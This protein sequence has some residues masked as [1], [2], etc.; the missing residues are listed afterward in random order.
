MG[1][2]RQVIIVGD[3][4][5]LPP[6]SFFERRVEDGGEE[7]TE[8]ETHDLDSILDEC[9]GAGI[10][11]VELTWHYRS[12]HE[13]LIAFSNNTYYG[14]RLVTFPSPVTSDQAVSF[15]H[16]PGG[17]YARAA[18]RTNEVEARAVVAEALRVLRA[19]PPRSLGIVTF[20]AEQQSLIEDLFDRA[21][22]DDP[23]LEHHFGDDAAEPV[24]V[25]NLEGI[26]GE[27]RD[28]MLFSLTYGPDQTGSIG[29]NFGPLNLTGGERRLNVAVTR[30]REKL[31]VFGS[32]RADQIDLSRTAATGVAHLKQFLEFAE[33]GARAFATEATG[34]LGDHESPFEAEVA[35][36]L[37]QKGWVVHP[38]IGVSGFRIDLAVVDPD[39]PGAF[40]AGVECDGATYHRAAT[41][42]D[43]DR[44]RQMVLE[45][46]GWSILRI[47][48]TDWWTNAGR[49]TD[50][51]HAALEAALARAR[52]R[53]QTAALTVADETVRAD[54]TSQADQTILEPAELAASEAQSSEPASS[55]GVGGTQP[56][57][58]LFY[59]ENY[60]TRLAAI[61]AEAVI[62]LAPVR[63][64]RLVQHIARLHGFG[65]VGREIRE[66]ILALLPEVNAV[67]MEEGMTF[68][69]PSDTAP[70]AWAR[71]R[72]P[73]LGMALDPSDLPLEELTVLARMCTHP[74]MSDETIL[75]AMRDACG[76]RR[77][78]GESRQRFWRA[79][80]RSRG[81]L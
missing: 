44:L 31:L 5:Q 38:Q 79:L 25:K 63:D 43:R 22:R 23:M 37:R 61:V 64:D 10:A 3:P 26:Q 20:N 66:R 54:L 21:R 58:A 77:L 32:L 65:R 75:Q 1:R 52:E 42:R 14:G 9:L 72:P 69:W 34:S 40:L 2:G 28:V 35:E 78:V 17:V 46:L 45:G 51:L 18:A 68:I 76:F 73:A 11:T 70:S 41:A 67:T 13:S 30:A 59:E 39:A 8:T 56:D 7:R 24:L 12:R 36:R 6:T 50:R 27:E 71:F 47:W 57:P 49:E 4:R 19:E 53:H 81:A 55:I 62:A 33:H 15:H 48:S 60:Q 74:D 16:V 80:D 29:L